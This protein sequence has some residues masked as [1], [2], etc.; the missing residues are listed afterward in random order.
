MAISYSL[1]KSLSCRLLNVEAKSIIYGP[2]EADN[3][4]E[5]KVL[6]YAFFLVFATNVSITKP[7]VGHIHK[8]SVYFACISQIIIVL[9]Q[10][11][12]CKPG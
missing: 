8:E 2:T 10:L 5:W 7:N 12:V 3:M 9:L 11:Y 6:K 4:A 1:S